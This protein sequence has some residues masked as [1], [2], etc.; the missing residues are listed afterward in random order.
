MKKIKQFSPGDKVFAKVKG[1]PA[2][3]AKVSYLKKKIRLDIFQTISN[4]RLRKNLARN[5]K[6]TF[7]ELEKRKNTILILLN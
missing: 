7:M 2:W 4:Y 6:F 3:P 1:Y 5:T